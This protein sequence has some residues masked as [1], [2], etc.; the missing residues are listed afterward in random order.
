MIK[1]PVND[2]VLF[3]SK[4]FWNMMPFQMLKN[5]KEFKLTS[6]FAKPTPLIKDYFL[7]EREIISLQNRTPTPVSENPNSKFTPKVRTLGKHF[8][9]IEM[10]FRPHYIVP[11]DRLP[12]VLEIFSFFWYFYDLIEG[13]AF[14]L[15]ELYLCMAKKTYSDLAHDIHICLI[16]I[17]LK[18]FVH[19]Q[20]ISFEKENGAFFPILEH[21]GMKEKHRQVLV[22]MFWPEFLKE[23]LIRKLLDEESIEKEV[24]ELLVEVQGLDLEPEEETQKIVEESL[25][26]LLGNFSF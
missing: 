8:N 15:E 23:L 12:D 4:Y 24:D 25:K 20:R 21:V 18:E 26:P 9:N 19:K 2:H 11:E 17:Y 10:L 3:E 1:Y 13:P 14:D 16:N 22:R 7:K 5:L 6:P